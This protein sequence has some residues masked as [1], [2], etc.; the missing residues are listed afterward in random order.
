MGRGDA[1]EEGM[2]SHSSI[3]T[4]R[5]PWTVKPGGLKIGTWFP[6]SLHTVSFIL[7]ILHSYGTSVTV[8]KVILSQDFVQISLAFT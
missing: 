5:I 1:L 7:N 8:I 2:T 4:W 3:L 6:Y